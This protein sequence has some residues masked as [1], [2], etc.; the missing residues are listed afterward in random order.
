MIYNQFNFNLKI[1]YICE[2]YF[3][4]IFFLFIANSLLAIPVL[5]LLMAL[6][7]VPDL[8]SQCLANNALVGKGRPAFGNI[9]KNFLTKNLAI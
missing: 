4:L 6:I 5:Q 8:A 7:P 2:I 9:I 3:T 1:P